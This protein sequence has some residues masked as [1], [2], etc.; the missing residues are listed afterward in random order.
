MEQKINNIL[1]VAYMHNHDV[2]VL[3]ALGCGAYHNPPDQVAQIFKDSLHKYDKCFKRVIFAVL[4]KKD[5][6]YQVFSSVLNI[7]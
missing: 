3:G 1:K 2:L 5:T 6:N 7:T 4:S